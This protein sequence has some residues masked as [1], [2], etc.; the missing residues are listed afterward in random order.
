MR[1]IVSQSLIKI[2]L[3]VYIYEQKYP[4]QYNKYLIIIEKKIPNLTKSYFIIT[5]YA[6]IIFESWPRL[7]CFSLIKHFSMKILI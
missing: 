7:Q 6:A 4:N 3:C 5:K 1:S 2:K